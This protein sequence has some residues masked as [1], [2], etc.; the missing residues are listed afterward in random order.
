M[1]KIFIITASGGSYDDA[2]ENNL[3]AVQSQEGA[4]AEVERLNA[5][6][7]LLCSIWNEVRAALFEGYAKTRSVQQEP[8]PPA[9]K[10]PAK[11]GGKDA[12]R[13]HSKALEE[14]RA[15]AEPARVRNAAVVQQSMREAVESA[16]QKAVELGAD[17]EQLQALGFIT[18][19]DGS[20]SP[21]HLMIDTSYSYE[22]LEL[23]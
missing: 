12:Q 10:G 3:F 16:R 15:A 9:P 17:D 4:E 21:P 14:W 13:A 23:R 19:A 6:H 11:P 5:Q 20:T 18:L 7:A 1:T 8:V 22:E 2:W